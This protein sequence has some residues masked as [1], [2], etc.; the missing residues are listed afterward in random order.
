M[1]IDLHVHSTASDGTLTP[2]QVIEHAAAQGVDVVGL[3]DHDSPAG[4]AEGVEA[5]R[6]LDVMLVPGME[7]STKLGR[8]GVHVLAYLPDPAFPPLA[9]ELDRIIAGREGRL[10]AIVEQLRSVGVDITVDDVRRQAA[11]SPAIG[12]PHV[13]DV[14]VA[15]GVVSDRAEAFRGWLGY[16]QP[17]FV[18]RYATQTDAMVRLIVGAGGAAVIAHPWGR[19]SRRV[20]DVDTLAA[21]RDAGLT[22]IE[23]DHQ[24]HSPDDRQRL[25]LIADDLGL[26]ATGAS[27]FHGAGKVDH[28]LGCN[29]TSPDQ[30]E[31]L[32]GLAAVNAASSGLRV[33]EVVGR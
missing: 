29:L 12:R 2:T 28:E 13:A 5:A 30:F 10:G 14:L 16:G 9:A 23:V 20:L 27:D 3:T 22:G 32:L 26:V 33:A 7:V 21:L 17:G 8:A 25:R 1:R 31:R 4:W 19:G 24:D 15:K 18:V 11:G 6:D